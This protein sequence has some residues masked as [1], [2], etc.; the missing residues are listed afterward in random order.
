MLQ[1]TR[2]VI[3]RPTFIVDHNTVTR[4]SGVQIDWA[5]VDAET[6]EEADG[7][8]RL[9]AGTVIGELLGSGKASPRVETTNPATGI[10]E[11]DAKEDSLIDSMSGYG[12]LRSG[13]I[14]ENL[15]PDAAGGP[16]AV[17]DSDVKT[18]LQSNCPIGFHFKTYQDN[19][20]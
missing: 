10:L 4:D 13:A 19:R 16:P 1:R 11:T 17:L 9:P 8:K 5:N 15:L 7:K 18:E 14:Y 12:V 20:A 3:G 2:T 6:Y